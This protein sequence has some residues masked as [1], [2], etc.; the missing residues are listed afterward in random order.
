MTPEMQNWLAHQIQVVL[1]G[2]DRL[3]LATWL[4]L[5]EVQ[6]ALTHHLVKR[7]SLQELHLSKKLFRANGIK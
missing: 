3:F 6:K 5:E 7:F 1:V 4:H 2:T